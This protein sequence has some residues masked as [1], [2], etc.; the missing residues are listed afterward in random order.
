LSLYRKCVQQFI[1]TYESPK[2]PELWMKLV[3]EEADEVFE[4]TAN[5]LKE[6]SDFS[7]V[8]QGLDIV[9]VDNKQFN[10]FPLYMQTKIKRVVQIMECFLQAFPN[11]KIDEAFM[12]VHAS[13]MSKLGDDGKPIRRS[14]GKILKGPNYKAPDLL[15]LVY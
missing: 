2:D 4:A 13:N 9:N 15:D 6:Y 7:Y 3:N 5:L 8:I 1:D 12:L 11:E 10:D 14:D